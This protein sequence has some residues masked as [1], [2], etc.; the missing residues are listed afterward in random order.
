MQNHNPN[1]QGQQHAANASPKGPAATDG[2]QTKAVAAAKDA[3]LQEAGLRGNRT[4][5][6]SAS[7]KRQQAHRD[8]ADDPTSGAINDA[9][10]TSASGQVD[11]AESEH[12]TDDA[13]LIQVQVNTDHNIHGSAH[14]TE[15]IIDTVNAALGR[16]A[17]RLTR[18][19]IHL[20]DDNGGKTNG[21]DKRC[22]LEARPANHQP[23][24]V[25]HVAGTVDDA[26][27]GAL[28]TMTQLLTST[29]ARLYDPKGRPSLGE[30]AAR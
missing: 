8:A 30:E 18:V 13:H 27:D 11:G 23:I 28:R 7:V 12:D 9:T 5:E 2:P 16:F 26:V 10:A 17:K 4:G 14:L 24:V 6:V 3:R 22:L 15:T 20:S 21:D 29:F 19:E 25:T 1:D